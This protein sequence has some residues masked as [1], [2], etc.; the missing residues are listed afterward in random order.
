MEE[1]L[2]TEPD[3]RLVQYWDHGEP[4]VVETNIFCAACVAMALTAIG[5]LIF[6]AVAS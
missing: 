5:W 6:M 2:P 1:Q 3:P 4:G